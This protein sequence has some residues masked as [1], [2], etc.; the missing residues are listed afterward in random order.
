M[1]TDHWNRVTISLAPSEAARS[2]DRITAVSLKGDIV[3]DFVTV[4]PFHSATVVT[5]RSRALDDVAPCRYN[6]TFTVTALP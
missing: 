6:V 2:R 3:T 4:K 1:T 5:L